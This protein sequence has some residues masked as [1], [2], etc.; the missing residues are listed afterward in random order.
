MLGDLFGF[1]GRTVGT[2]CGIAVAPI[3]LALGV[4]ERLVKEA[5]R[6]GCRTEREIKRWIE[7]NT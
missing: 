3:A 7:N 1:V 2:L 6:A 5:I 4:S